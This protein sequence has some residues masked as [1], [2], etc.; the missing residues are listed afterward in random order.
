MCAKMLINDVNLGIIYY[1]T[2]CFHLQVIFFTD[3]SIH[4][5]FFC[6]YQ[7]NNPQAVYCTL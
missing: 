5:L 7:I 4:S 6:I 3:R 2:N 1:A